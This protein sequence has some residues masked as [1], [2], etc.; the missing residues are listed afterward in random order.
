MKKKIREIDTSLSYGLKKNRKLIII[1]RFACIA[2]KHNKFLIEHI[3]D[4]KI[5]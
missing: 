3:K 2:R 4:H 1:L 5:L